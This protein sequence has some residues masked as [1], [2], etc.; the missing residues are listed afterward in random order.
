M[1]IVGLGCNF[2]QKKGAGLSSF[3]SYNPYDG[4]NLSHFQ[5]ASSADSFAAQ[6]SETDSFGLVGWW[7]IITGGRCR[8]FG[9]LG[10]S[11]R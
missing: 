11:I 3:W 4:C 10:G 6:T 8:L 5:V 7:C 1:H 9:G 2:G